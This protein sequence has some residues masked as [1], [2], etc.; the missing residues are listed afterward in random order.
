MLLLLVVAVAAAAVAVVVVAV[1]VAAAAAAVAVA[2][3]LSWLCLSSRH[4]GLRPISLLT[5]SYSHCLTQT[6]REIPH[7]HGNFTP[8]H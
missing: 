4:N 6:F 2:V 7:G 1:V 5:F 8:Q 3:S